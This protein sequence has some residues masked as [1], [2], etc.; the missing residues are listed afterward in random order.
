[1]IR[2]II[3]LSVADFKSIAR[4]STLLL[5]LFGPLA[6]LFFLRFGVPQL[7]SVVERQFA[8]DLAEYHL[9]IF[10]FM[11]LIPSMLFGM[12]A[13]FIML[14]D[15][16]QDIVAF[17]TV[18][19]LRKSGYFAYKL[20]SLTLLSFG[21]FFVFAAFAGLVRL[22]FIEAVMLAIVIALEAPL[23]A[24]FLAAF[25]ENKVEGLALSKALGVIYAGPFVAFFMASDWQFAAG[26]LPPFWIAKA[27]LHAIAGDALFWL[28][29]AVGLLWHLLAIGWLLK[30]FLGLQ[31]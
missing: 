30:R 25:A 9:F 6:L 23:I 13:G 26:L 22:P 21:F 15:R 4:E 5:V 1:M 10:A 19:P 29:S 18:T 12:I 31:R 14:D 8:V 20:L 2:K 24:L 27:Y 7:A 3:A 16:D 11:S 17:I 28:Y